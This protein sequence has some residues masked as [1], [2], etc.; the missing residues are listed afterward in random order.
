[1]K[2]SIWWHP[3]K[4]ICGFAFG[5]MCAS[6]SKGDLNVFWLLV[7]FLVMSAVA[8]IFEVELSHREKR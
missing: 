1:M 7:P 8:V 4:L 3:F 5:F 2:R 6:V